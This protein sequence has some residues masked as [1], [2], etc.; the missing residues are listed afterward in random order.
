LNRPISAAPAAIIAKRMINARFVRQDN[1]QAIS[2]ELDE[3]I[4]NY[5]YERIDAG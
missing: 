3:H 4:R 1:I 2:G 5:P